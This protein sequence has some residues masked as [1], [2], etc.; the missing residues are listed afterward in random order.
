MA[1]WTWRD[2]EPEN[3][4]KGEIY[5]SSKY[6]PNS[7]VDESFITIG[8]VKGEA[9]I[10]FEKY[11]MVD[12]DPDGVREA[13]GCLYDP[14]HTFTVDESAADP[15]VIFA[16]TLT[17]AGDVKQGL[18]LDLDAARSIFLFTEPHEVTAETLLFVTEK[19]ESFSLDVHAMEELIKK[20]VLDGKDAL[21]LMLFQFGD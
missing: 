14:I 4:E 10:L 19:A 13:Y 9:K 20:D 5:Y 15:A 3:P 11:D 6:P 2:V 17:K 18:P 8:V 7:S 16:Y 1:F 21:C 12:K